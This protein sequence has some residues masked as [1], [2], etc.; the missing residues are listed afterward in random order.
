MKDFN[1]EK[2]YYLITII[3]SLIF[4]FTFVYNIIKKII[5]YNFYKKID[6]LKENFGSYEFI[7]DNIPKYYHISEKN[8]EKMVKLNFCQC[9]PYTNLQ[10]KYKMINK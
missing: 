7:Y 4:I 5:S 9:L 6:L 1:M 8:L 3:G 10:N 2:F